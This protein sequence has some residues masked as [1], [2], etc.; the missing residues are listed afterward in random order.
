M[1]IE[2]TKMDE[3]REILE[4]LMRRNEGEY[5]PGWTV[6]RIDPERQ[7]VETA[8][9]THEEA[10]ELLLKLVTA[11][12]QEEAENSTNHEN[13]TQ[14]QVPEDATGHEPSTK[15]DHQEE[16]PPSKKPRQA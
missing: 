3:L 16:E 11:S 14:N 10:Q 13:G 2:R 1:P 12:Q 8:M 4:R 9:V 15:N 5:H 7:R 6:T